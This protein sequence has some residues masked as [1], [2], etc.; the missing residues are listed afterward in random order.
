MVKLVDAYSLLPVMY[1]SRI[2]RKINNESSHKLRGET[3]NHPIIEKNTETKKNNKKTCNEIHNMKTTNKQKQTI[4]QINK[5]KKSDENSCDC[6]FYDRKGRAFFRQPMT[7]W[8]RPTSLC[9]QLL[10]PKP[11]DRYWT[12]SLTVR[13]PADSPSRGGD[14]AVYVFAVHQPSVPTPFY[15]VLVSLWPFQL[16]FIP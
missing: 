11:S 8:W 6:F 14:V 1:C 16:Y 7:S 4:K 9:L 13:V 5:E 3:D 10:C 2:W 12:I 15:S